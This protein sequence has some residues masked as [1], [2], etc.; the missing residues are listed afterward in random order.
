M[1]FSGFVFCKYGDKGL[2]KCA[3]SKLPTQQKATDRDTEEG[4]MEGDEPGGGGVVWPTF[5]MF[6]GF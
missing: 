1:I 4:T 5:E 2:G 6:G 3:F